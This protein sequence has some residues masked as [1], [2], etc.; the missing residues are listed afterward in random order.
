MMEDPKWMEHLKTDI[1][2]NLAESAH[3]QWSQ[4][5]IVRFHALPFTQHI[6]QVLLILEY[7]EVHDQI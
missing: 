1:G 4:D 5:D 6:D 7:F 3:H 2:R